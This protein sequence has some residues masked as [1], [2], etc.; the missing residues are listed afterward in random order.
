VISFLFAAV[1]ASAPP[2][3]QPT[4]IPEMWDAWC[5]RCHAAD[6]SGRVSEPTIAVQPMDFSDCSVT[7][8]EPDADWE[9]AIAKG[10]P[11][12]GLSSQMP[13]FEDSLSPEQI[14]GFV[15]HMRT[16]CTE[17]R[18]PS[19]NL[20]FPRPIVT[21]KAFP[22]NEFL[23][24]PVVSHSKEDGGMPAVT[25]IELM[26]VFERR[27]GKR[28]MYEIGIP[29]V[30]RQTAALSI[31]SAGLINTQ[32]T[33]FGVGDIELAFKY[34][35]FASEPGIL[36]AGVEA[37]I[38]FGNDP[39]GFGHGTVVWEPF[40]AAGTTLGGWYLQAQTKYEI[41]VDS[42]RADRAFVYN[43]YLG[44]DTSQA[45]NTWTLGVEL[46]GENRE[47]FVTPQ[48]RKGLTRTGALA[49]ALGAMIPVTEREDQTTRLVG[50]LLWEYME[51]VRARR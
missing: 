21:E 4:T 35:V 13:A 11:G 49:A 36:A 39:N 20:N 48:I 15:A 12:V 26:N 46:N 16:F 32:S 2:V 30:G 7:S 50:Y 3:E 47:L 29:V 24:L 1:L 28:A 33:N 45:P 18:W 34:T 22:E 40:L 8:P 43:L 27:I 19:G 23:I 25:E 41:P 37:A 14:R 17:R 5:A 42:G 31:P 44:R 51:P 10:G 38:P 6:G 9:R